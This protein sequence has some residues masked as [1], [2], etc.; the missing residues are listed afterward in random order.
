MSK[1][2]INNINVM[3]DN[4]EQSP[5]V[6]NSVTASFQTEERF[7]ALQ[8]IN[9]AKRCLHCK[10]PMCV[11]GCPIGNNIPEF[12]HQLSKGNMG[13]AL[14]IINE[15]STLPAICGRVCPHENQCQGNCVLGRKGNPIKI[16]K[17]E[18]FLADFDTEMNLLRE[19]LPQKTRG[20]IAVI[21]SGPAGLT[22]A[23]QLARR[24]FH[25]TIFES[26]R[27]L[28]G[29]L[30]YGIPEYRLPKSVVR[31][32]VNKI[33]SLGVEFRTGATVGVDNLTVDSIFASGYDAIF[34]GTGTVIPK[35][36]IFRV[37]ISM[38]FINQS[39][40]YTKLQHTMMELLRNGIFL[41]VPMKRLR[42]LDVETLL[43]MLPERLFGLELM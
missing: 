4:K 3:G 39:H 23:G 19:E 38:A 9:E 14:S 42:L 31:Q 30:L 20:K 24:G 35:Q 8:A 12:I 37:L 17:L 7:T 6:L 16:G 41:F 28:G 27:E 34:I 15:T 1:D 43:W 10:N 2:L 5:I 40:Y 29:V 33:E 13:A 11:K 21:G 25:V 32:E 18:S 22:V 26:Q 36:L